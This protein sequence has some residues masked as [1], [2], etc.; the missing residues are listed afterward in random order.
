MKD[1]YYQKIILMKIQLLLK[2]LHR[3]MVNTVELFMVDHQENKKE[4][5]KLEIKFFLTGFRKVLITQDI[6]K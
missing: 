1:F 2:S 3:D 5:F 6:L 4:F